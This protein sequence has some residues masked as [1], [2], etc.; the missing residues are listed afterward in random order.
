M[1]A[2][3]SLSKFHFLKGLQC[4]KSLWLHTHEPDASEL[5]TDPSVQR[6]I[7]NEVRVR[8]R[9]RECFPGGVAIDAKSGDSALAITETRRHIDAGTKVLF[10]AVFSVEGVEV[11]ADVLERKGKI[12]TLIKTKASRNV[13]PEV[14]TDAAVQAYFLRSAGL[15]VKRIE[16]LHLNKECKFPDLTDLFL[17]VD[18]TE[19]ANAA[20]ENI[21][22]SAKKILKAFHAENEPRVGAGPHCNEPRTCP[23]HE[24][25]NTPL[26][27]DHIDVLY[28]MHNKTKDSL[29]AKGLKLVGDVAKAKDIRLSEV[30]KRQI[31]AITTSKMVV[32]ASLESALSELRSPLAFLDFETVMPL[33]PVWDG[34]EP[35]SQVPA[36]F[37][38]HV[39][40]KDGLAHIGWIASGSK[41][42]RPDLA[43][44]LIAALREAKTI[45]VYDKKTEVGI[46]RQLSAACPDLAPQLGEIIERI[47]DLLPVVTN[48]VY[49]PGFRGSFGLKIVLPILCPDLSYDRL[50]IQDGVAAMTAIED[51]L[52]DA[53]QR[54]KEETEG[55]VKALKEYCALDT[56]ALVKM[57]ER[58]REMALK[59]AG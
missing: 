43:R 44:A 47:Y 30:Q 46:I 16:I 19:G 53:D 21:K 52:F 45:V 50:A 51:V 39:E 24:R 6:K 54:P 5:V 2:G 29:V 36:Q 4:E 23:F 26:P 25:C 7:R 31:K 57:V 28:R 55:R 59:K 1:T 33:F 40:S 10:D 37:S 17:R 8:I 38:C 12:W 49:H 27:E 41:D 15:D 32:D 13:K 56:L 20:A 48:H 34:C 42:P 35:L 14:I 3:S 58:L 18:V 9:A 22:M 11:R